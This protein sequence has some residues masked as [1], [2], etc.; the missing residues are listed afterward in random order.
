[1]DAERINPFVEAAFAA[2]GEVTGRGVGRGPVVV[3]DPADALRGSCC[4]AGVTGDLD[5]VV[6][7]DMGEPEALALAGKVAGR[8]VSRLG[9]IEQVA[10]FGLISLI[11]R[12]A[13][14]SLEQQGLRCQCSTP[15]LLSGADLRFF[16][17]EREVLTVGLTLSI[18]QV[19]L[20]LALREVRRG[21]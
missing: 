13:L 10:V 16:F 15:A 3:R 14:A 2:F 12:Q 18:G 6:L 8:G 5:G 7:F 20:C 19:D 11:V 1:M 17:G 9:P 4:I 21:G